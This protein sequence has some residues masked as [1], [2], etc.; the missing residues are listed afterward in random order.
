MLTLAFR[1][2]RQQL[3][4]MPQNFLRHFYIIHFLALVVADFVVLVVEVGVMTVVFVGHGF[5]YHFLAVGR[6][7][8]WH[9]LVVN[10][11]FVVDPFV[12]AAVHDFDCQVPVVVRGF[13]VADSFVV[14]VVRDFD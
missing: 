1:L 8:D 5:D 14:V 13:V 2:G 10:F 6:D 7:F 3:S 4:K 9:F 11:C 12:V